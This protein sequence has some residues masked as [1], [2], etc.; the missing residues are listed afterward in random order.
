MK[1]GRFTFQFYKINQIGTMNPGQ[2]YRLNMDSTMTLIYPQPFGQQ[3]HSI[4]Q[5]DETDFTP[6]VHF[7]FQAGTGANATIIIPAEIHAQFSDDS[8]LM[9]GDEIGV[10]NS[11]GVCCGATVW[12]GENTALTI[13]GDD[14]R[15][16]EIDGLNPGE[17]CQFPHLAKRHRTRIPGDG[18]I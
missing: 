18:Q 5:A 1:K 2:G 10:F 7:E 6:P 8:P 11:A 3:S 13:W 15:T 9:P 17:A 12:Q 4:A 14:A 16:E